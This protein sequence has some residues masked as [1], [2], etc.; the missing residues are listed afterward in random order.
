MSSCNYLLIGLPEILA[1]YVVVVRKIDNDHDT[2]Y[3]LFTKVYQRK[4]KTIRD[5]KKTSTNSINPPSSN[6]AYIISHNS[7]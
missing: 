3:L 5:V 4:N 7:L 1:M 2:I 6:N